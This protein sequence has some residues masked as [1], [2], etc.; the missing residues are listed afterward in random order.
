MANSNDDCAPPICSS[1][2]ERGHK[3]A[4]SNDC[5]N[6]KPTKH[7]EFQRLMGNHSTT[8]RKIKL[9]TILRPQYQTLMLQK[10]TRTCEDLRNIVIRAQLFMNYYILTTETVH[11]KAF[12]QDCFYCVAQL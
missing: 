1:C 6:H 4:R 8:C 7:Q 2:Q 12:T 9:S 11:K 5:P 10:I 3:S